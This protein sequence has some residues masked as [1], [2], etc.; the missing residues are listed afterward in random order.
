MAWA[1]ALKPVRVVI[2]Y[3]KSRGPILASGLAF[4]GLFAVFGGLWVGFSIAGFVIARNLGLR[5]SL[6]DVLAQTIPGLIQTSGTDGGGTTGIIDPDILLSAGVFGWTGAL[7]LVILLFAALNWLAAARDATRS[8]FTLPH[9]E[10]NL[11]LLKV[12][13]FGLAL[14]FG[15]LLLVSAGLS[16][17]GTLALDTALQWVGIRDTTL[18]T[19]LGRTITLAVMFAL[20]AFAL[21]MLYRVLSGVKIPLA[22]LR[23]GALIGAFALGVL[24]VVGGS[25]LG[26]ASN[27]PLLTGFAVLLGL[28]IWLNF[29]CQVILIAAAWIAVGVRDDGIVLDEKVA[30]ERLEQARQL[31]AENETQGSPDDRPWW[32]RLFGRR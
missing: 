10:T 17:V 21:G 4:Q 27:N 3:G 2:H 1:K 11:V 13:D 9:S 8:L 16:V 23:Q 24:K 28:L 25:L 32:R 31:V 7:A 29:A 26:G 30:A 20:D 15:A 22:P 18:S 19:F 12:K 14:G 6:I 5:S